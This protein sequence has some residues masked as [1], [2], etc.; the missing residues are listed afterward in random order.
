VHQLFDFKKACESVW[1]EVL[2]NILSE[3]GIP[4]K[5]VK[6]MKIC[7]NETYS[8]VRVGKYLSGMFQFRDGLKQ[9]D[10]LS[11]LL[12]NCELEYA[13]RRVQVNQYG[14]KRNS[15]HQLLVYADGVNILGK[16]IDTRKKNTEALI[17]ASKE[18]GL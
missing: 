18:I 4:M 2:Y 14:L 6:L 1:R 12:F 15:T 9:G 5:L 13:I 10:T 3:L 7:L 8:R 16:S 11:A 17:V